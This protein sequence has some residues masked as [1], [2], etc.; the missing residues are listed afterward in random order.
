D[1]V[2]AAFVHGGVIGEVINRTFFEAVNQEKVSPAG[3][4]QIEQTKNEAGQDLEYVATFEVYPEVSL[5]D[6]S[7][8]EIIK[9]NAQVEDKDIDQMI[10]VLRQ[11]QAKQIDVD[12]AAEDGDQVNI[13]YVGTRDGEEFQ[14]GSAQGSNLV[15]GSGQ[16]I[17]GFEDGIIG[18]KAGEEK[19]ISLTFP[20]DYHSEELKGA[21]VEFAIKLNGVKE[22]QLPELDDEFFAAFG[23]SEGGEDKFREEVRANMER[24]LKNAL[25]NK[26][27]QRI[28]SKLV[29][30]HDF[31]VPTALVKNEINGMK[32]QML[33]QFGGGAGFDASMLPDDMFTDR[34]EKR[35]R[36]GLIFSEV[37]KANKIKPDPDKVRLKIEEIASTYEEP[38]E[39]VSYY[40]NNQEL[41][42][43]I[44]SVVA[45]DE[46]IKVLES[47]MT[48]T[49]EQVDYEV[50]VKPDPE[51]TADAE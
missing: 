14:G 33:Q 25:A 24:E 46:I 7:S 39:V 28:V 48:I 41:L 4:P 45:E 37:V 35:V 30:L 1:E 42:R 32:Q 44:E 15:L 19:T 40:Y 12:R 49:E 18:M 6:V 9:Q 11:Q 23:V 20:E 51:D 34:A 27:K 43:S 50:A 3:Q 22:K 31:V 13:D 21:A 16:M 36:S 8:V 47:Q 29:E 38:E 2:V 26:L 17:P 10:D 5:A